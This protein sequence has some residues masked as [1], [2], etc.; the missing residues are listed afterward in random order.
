MRE[1]ALE[2][3]EKNRTLET[4][5]RNHILSFVSQVPHRMPG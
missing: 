5:D 1:D 4:Q 3:K 2:I